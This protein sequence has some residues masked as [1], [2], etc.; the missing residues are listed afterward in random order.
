MSFFA[1]SAKGCA[2]KFS[3]STNNELEEKNQNFSSDQQIEERGIDTNEDGII[4]DQF[5]KE[6]METQEYFE[7]EEEME[8]YK[9]IYQENENMDIYEEENKENEENKNEVNRMMHIR[10]TPIAKNAN[11][12]PSTGSN[13]ERQL[14][15]IQDSAGVKLD[16]EVNKRRTNDTGIN[17]NDV[18]ND[19]NDSNNDS[20]NNN[21]NNNN[22]N[23]I[24]NNNIIENNALPF[25]YVEK[26]IIQNKTLS[27][28]PQLENINIDQSNIK[29]KLKL[30]QEK[31]YKETDQKMEY[32]KDNKRFKVKSYNNNSNNYTNNQLISQPIKSLENFDNNIAID[33]LNLSNQSFKKQSTITY[34]P[35]Q[36]CKYDNNILSKSI[37]NSNKLLQREKDISTSSNLS[38]I[39]RYVEEE[40]QSIAPP[41][42]YR[43]RQTSPNITTS[44]TT[45]LDELVSK[46]TNKLN[47]LE[48]LFNSEIE[49]YESRIYQLIDINNK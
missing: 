5:E 2:F 21:N 32:I 15:S 20:N 19:N 12:P 49:N 40:Q 42:I 11:Q 41:K 47:D 39:N 43:Q 18:S 46:I 25:K 17:N 16:L 45:N 24:I 34:A 27:T 36:T 33:N 13:G 9:Q 4:D 22:N 1:A 48:P 23:E 26:M 7:N 29:N 37:L 44:A 6:R 10:N 28:K 30:N 14:K 3:S 31:K 8:E 35:K 38:Q